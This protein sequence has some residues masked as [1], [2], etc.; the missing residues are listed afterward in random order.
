ME[1]EEIALLVQLVRVAVE[2]GED[3][4]QLRQRVLAHLHD[5]R[6]VRLNHRHG[7]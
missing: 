2:E 1:L 6:L 3:A 7:T 5:W 4:L